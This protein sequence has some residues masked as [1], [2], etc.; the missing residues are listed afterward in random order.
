MLTHVVY[1]PG[2]GD[3]YDPFRRLA[4]KAWRLGGVKVELVPM[5]WY[6]Q[7]DELEQKRE[8]VRAAIGR[9]GKNDIII[10]GESAG[11]AIALGFASNP[12][13]S[14]VITIAG[15]SRSNTPIAPSLRKRSPALLAAT[16]TIPATSGYDVHSVRAI[17]DSVL[18]KKYSLATGSKAHVV[19]TF[20]HFGTIVMCLSLLSPLVIAIAKKS[21]T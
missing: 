9:A 15:V 12:M 19:W 14:R 16:R 13:V 18:D 6:G 8:R 2:L 17:F 20:G 7:E 5:H 3:G 1:I 11:A 4:L 21:K 10:I